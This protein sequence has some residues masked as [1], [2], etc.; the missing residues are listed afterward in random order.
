MFDAMSGE[1]LATVLV[2]AIFCAVWALNSLCKWMAI[3]RLGY[4]PEN[5]KLQPKDE[6]V[7]VKQDGWVASDTMEEPEWRDR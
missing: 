6:D 5:C 2:V 3:Y 7:D 4:L 1:Q